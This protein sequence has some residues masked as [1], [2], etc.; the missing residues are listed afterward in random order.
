MVPPESPKA[1]SKKSKKSKKGK[2]DSK[3]SRRT[4][5][6]E[7]VQERA[8][9]DERSRST[10]RQEP[11]STQQPQPVQT[12]VSDTDEQSRKESQPAGQDRP[13]R[14]RPRFDPSRDVAAAQRI[15]ERRRV[16]QPPREHGR[17]PATD[18][19]P[20]IEEQEQ[21]RRRPPPPPPATSTRQA[22]LVHRSLAF[23]RPALRRDPVTE[24][25]QPSDRQPLR[26][27]IRS[28][29]TPSQRPMPQRVLATPKVGSAP[30]RAYATPSRAT[31]GDYYDQSQVRDDRPHASQYQQERQ[32]WGSSQRRVPSMGRRESAHAW[33]EQ[34]YSGQYYQDWSQQ[35]PSTQERW[36]DPR[37]DYQQYYPQ[38]SSAAQHWPVQQQ[39]QL[40]Q[41]QQMPSLPAPVYPPGMQ[42]S[43][44][45]PPGLGPNVQ[46]TRQG[47]MSQSASIH[48]GSAASRQQSPIGS[49]PPQDRQQSS[50]GQQYP[51][52]GGYFRHG[53]Q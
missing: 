6:D 26:L 10:R 43:A 18:G 45:P 37:Q 50:Y 40:Q 32:D 3:G 5:R 1:S 27:R 15:T 49:Q 9:H 33:A 44:H 39:Q 53:Y 11:P 22:Q 16:V 48:Y 47:V 38:Q 13:A 46:R 35:L 31:R 36:H 23:A 8:T 19:P 30:P 17:D 2:K 29:E 25:S 28:Q 7:P 21:R 41:Q 4:E 42:P 34:Q 20:D 52:T 51:P 14:T 12:E 24:S